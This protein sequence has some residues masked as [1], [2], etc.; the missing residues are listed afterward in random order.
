MPAHLT[1][2]TNSEVRT[3]FGFTDI[4]EQMEPKA[5]RLRSGKQ[6]PAAK[7]D[8]ADADGHGTGGSTGKA[9]GL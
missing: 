3:Q 4:L 2:V 8:T 1:H 7:N 9:A 6:I 5:R